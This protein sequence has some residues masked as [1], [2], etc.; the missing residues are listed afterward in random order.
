MSTS[1]SPIFIV[2]NSDL[3]CHEL[4]PSSTDPSDYLRYLLTPRYLIDPETTS[5]EPPSDDSYDSYDSYDFT[6]LLG[7]DDIFVLDL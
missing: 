1:S 5:G 2:L 3:H 7:P 4:S 6:S